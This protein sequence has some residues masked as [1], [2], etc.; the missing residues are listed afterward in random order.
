MGMKPGLFSLFLC[1]LPFPNVG[2]TPPRTYNPN[3]LGQMPVGVS[4]DYG[5]EH[6]TDRDYIRADLPE[7]VVS[8]ISGP[9]PETTQDRTQ[10]NDTQLVP[11]QR[12]KFLTSLGIELG[13]LDWNPGTLPTTPRRWTNL[14]YEN[15]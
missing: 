10:T 4:K 1:Y 7:C 8:T 15:A 9:P 12:L 14:G 11:R 5:A 13:L 3:A 2:L 6:W